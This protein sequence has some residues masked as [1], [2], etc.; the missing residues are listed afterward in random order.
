ME[1]NHQDYRIRLSKTVWHYTGDLRAAKKNCCGFYTDAD[2]SAKIL[3]KIDSKLQRVRQYAVKAQL[4]LDHQEGLA[5]DAV[6]PAEAKTAGDPAI[7][8]DTVAAAN[9]PRTD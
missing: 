6:D 5:S 9:T 4:Q 3:N 7:G 2:I 8:D 1:A